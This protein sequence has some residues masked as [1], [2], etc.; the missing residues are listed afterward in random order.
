MAKPKPADGERVHLKDLKPSPRNPRKHTAT[1]IGVIADSLAEIG[2]WRSIS[3]DEENI[4]RAGNGVVEAAAE[5]GIENVRIVDAEGD[6]IIA[7]RRRGLTEEQK[8]RYELFDNRSSDLAEYDGEV[9]QEMSELGLTRGIFPDDEIES[10]VESEALEDLL[11]TKL[12]EEAD[13]E[14]A[15]D[16]AGKKRREIRPVLF[17][18]GVATFEAAIDATGIDDRGEALIEICRAY[19]ASK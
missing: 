11:G 13:G 17:A 4:V 9:L 1:N 5:R 14:G 7:V 15:A 8:R 16:A 12:D 3:I 19:L 18:E 2:A 6:E 10:I